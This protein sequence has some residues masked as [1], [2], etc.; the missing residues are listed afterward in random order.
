MAYTP[1]VA[2]I[3]KNYESD[4]PGTRA[5]LARMLNHGR[6]GGT[7]RMIILPVDQGFEHGPGRSFAMNPEGYD[8]HYHFQLAVDGGV[9]AFAA[10]LGLIEAG[11]HRFAGVVPTILKINSGN[12]L[13]NTNNQA[14]TGSVK[15]ALR[16]GCSG[17]GFTIYPGAESSYE[18]YEEIRSISEEAK[19]N[20]LVVVIWSYPRGN[21]SKTA[22]TAVDVIAYGAHMAS[23]LGAHIVKVKIPTHHLED[24]NAKG[25][26]EQ[27]KVDVGTSEAR[28]RHIVKACFAGRRIVVFSGGGTKGE[29]DVYDDARAIMAGGGQGSIIGRN[30]FQRPRDEALKMLDQL[31]EI[32]KG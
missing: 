11:A 9:S 7:G 19:Q 16:L 25:V 21:M 27:Y 15:E 14:L 5:N 22:E 4:C 8:P 1:A 32:Y 12:S 18:M 26:Y 17:I 3:L 29:A 30:V 28:I 10:P 20:G 24:E 6:L 23:L 2:A 13:V 31:V